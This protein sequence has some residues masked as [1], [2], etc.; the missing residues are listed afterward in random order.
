MG[1]YI[2]ESCLEHYSLRD[3]G[4]KSCVCPCDICVALK[5]DAQP[6]WC[7]YTYDLNDPVKCGVPLPDQLRE[8]ERVKEKI[9]E[10][11]KKCPTTLRLLV[12]R[13]SD[14][15]ATKDFYSTLGIEFRASTKRDMKHYVGAVDGFLMEIYPAD[16]HHREDHIRLGFGVIGLDEIMGLIPAS[17]GMVMKPPHDTVYGQ[18]ALVK[19]PD[20]RVVELLEKIPQSSLDGSPAPQ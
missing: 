1:L 2:C 14:I 20:G 12:I 7:H 10:R 13:S 17:R 8:F 5:L 15:D 18:K 11:V 19:D 4:A 6:I 16:S 3:S 9:T